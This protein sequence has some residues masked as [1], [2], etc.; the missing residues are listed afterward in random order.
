MTNSALTGDKVKQGAEEPGDPVAELV[1]AW[2]LQ[3]GTETVPIEGYRLTPR[4][5]PGLRSFS[6][7]ES[8]VFFGR[9]GH[10]RLL[11]NR[12]G[13]HNVLAVL[14]GSGSGKSSVV[15]AGLLPY[16][17]SGTIPDRPGRWYKAEMRPGTEPTSAM[18]EALWVQVCSSI[19]QKE[20]GN[21]GLKEAFDKLKS[22]EA[23]HARVDR[24]TDQIAS[25]ISVPPTAEDRLYLQK[26]IPLLTDSDGALSPEGL[27]SFADKT[28]DA[29]D[30]Q[31]SPGL[32]AAP[33][34][35]MILID[36]FEE[37]FRPEVNSNGRDAI[38]A[39]VKLVAEIGRKKP[40]PGLFIVLTM[41]SEE[42]HR[43][44]EYEGLS[45]VV[46]NSS[47]QLDLISGDREVTAAI[48]EP[49]REVFKSWGISYN[50]GHNDET[51][52][53]DPILVSQL[54]DQTARLRNALDHKPDSLPLLQHALQSI[55]NNGLERWER[56]I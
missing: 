43:C 20:F 29:M 40:R 22:Y 51:A 45:A 1:K 36:Q 12:L 4:P 52:P 41:R 16:L 7:S 50:E 25:R 21:I 2:R 26:F 39:L 34:N 6:S 14:G 11:A 19:R 13:Q 31:L 9:E 15:R 5:Y 8:S 35:L 24:L 3:A 18:V 17:T 28:L 42:L 56:L 23:D 48:V 47:V 53:F 10:G 49:A 55:W 44:S 33:A 27:L 46:V 54:R 30:A 32:Q 38:L 37:L